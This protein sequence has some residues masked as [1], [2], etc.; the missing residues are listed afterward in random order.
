MRVG[1]SLEC[2]KRV[3]IDF[4]CDF[5]IFHPHQTPLESLQITILGG[6]ALACVASTWKIHQ[7]HSKNAQKRHKITKKWVCS[8]RVIYKPV[9]GGWVTFWP[10]YPYFENKIMEKNCILGGQALAC[11]AST[12]KIEIQEKS[13]NHK[14]KYIIVFLGAFRYIYTNMGQFGSDLN[15]FPSFQ[16]FTHGK[17]PLET[18][19]DTPNG[20]QTTVSE[21]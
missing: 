9:S 2:F 3:C 18:L 6:Q 13:Q 16:N 5:S 17:I 19:P 21:A 7:N 4:F 15:S 1:E 14:K 20:P 12:W 11:V 8:V 10:R